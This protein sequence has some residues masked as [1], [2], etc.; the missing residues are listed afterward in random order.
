M[1]IKQ[2]ILRISKLRLRSKY[3]AR[4]LSQMIDKSDNYINRLENSN[5]N[6]PLKTLYD[7]L[8]ACE[9]SAEE[10]FYENFEDYKEDKEIIELLKKVDKNKKQAIISLLKS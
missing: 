7:I 9:C 1:D 3:S 8:E 2:T 4:E 5:F 10:F 6:I